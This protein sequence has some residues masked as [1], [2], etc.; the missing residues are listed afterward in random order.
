ME[1]KNI[2]ALARENI[3][4]QNFSFAMTREHGGQ[5]IFSRRRAKIFMNKNV[6]F[7]L[8]REHGNAK[9]LRAGARKIHTKFAPA[10]MP[11]HGNK[12]TLA[13]ARENIY[14]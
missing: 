8:R 6:S 3:Y 7:A 9:Y 2:F 5:K 14:D 13:L 10:L 11:E 1:I 12:N 4:T